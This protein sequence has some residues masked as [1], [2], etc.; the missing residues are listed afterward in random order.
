MKGW[1][2]WSLSEKLGK[3]IM[4]PALALFATLLISAALYASVI[5]RPIP[6]KASDLY[7]MVA[8]MQLSLNRLELDAWRYRAGQLARSEVDNSYAIAVSKYRMYSRPSPA[9]TALAQV[10]GFPAVKAALAELFE[11]PPRSW[12]QRD[13]QQLSQDLA[14]LR[15]TL[16]DFA[17]RARQQETGEMVQ[18][19]RLMESHQTL[20]LLGLTC[21]L[22][23]LCLFWIVMHRFGKVKRQASQQQQILEREQAARAALV[24]S[25]LARDTFLATIS[26]EIRSPLQSI[27]TCVELMEYSVARDTVCYGYLARLKHSTEHLLEQVRDIMDI[28][29]LKNLQLTLEPAATDIAALIAGIE[30]AHRSLA[31]AKGLALSIDCPAMPPLWLDGHR[32]RQIVWN[33]LS[34]A[35]RYTD[36]GR[37]DLTLRHQDKQLLILV[38][39]TG[40]GIADD[41]KAQLF[42]PFARGKTRRPGSSGLG[43]AIVHELV[44]LFGGRIQVASQPGQGSSFRLLLP[45]QEAADAAP[46]AED[47]AAPGRILLLDDDDQIRESYHAL[48]EAKGYAVDTVA[49]VPAAIEKVHAQSYHVL[50]LDLQ[51]GNA[52]GYEVA[53]AA[54]RTAVNLKTP[55]IGMTAFTQEFCDPRHTLL[56]GKL[57]KPFNF[58]Q[59]QKLLTQYLPAASL[60]ATK[61]A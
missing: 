50:L 2:D 56:T 33:L 11:K 60:G 20:Y 17:V 58:G 54:R 45:V 38:Q 19:L 35:I 3:G 24:Q 42:R 18:Q 1:R 9:N 40:V 55:V 51:V 53:E 23:F 16:A 41:L 8:Q 36:H 43:L 21:W 14:V 6:D 5:K 10:P 47:A 37:I 13:A 52:S 49:T 26:H 31:E 39:D 25:E 22:G 59:L 61:T 7:W 12:S 44:M 48:L 29:A 46:A 27:Q 32:L 4:F 28:S 57:E 15:P 34:N 30:L